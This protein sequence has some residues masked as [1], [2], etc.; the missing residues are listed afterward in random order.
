MRSRISMRLGWHSTAR[1]RGAGHG[2]GQR[3]RAAHAAEA[4]GQDPAAREVAA[5]VLAA[6]LDEGLV[7]ALHDAL[8]PI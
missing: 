6:D 7:G 1:Q 5:I 8:V 2:R 4:R 3:L